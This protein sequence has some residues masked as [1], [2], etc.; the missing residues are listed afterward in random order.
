MVCRP[1]TNNQTIEFVRNKD[2]N[3]EKIIIHSMEELIEFKD[4]LLAEGTIKTSSPAALLKRDDGTL[5][6]RRRLGR[7]GDSTSKRQ[8]Q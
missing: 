4:K 3:A 1:M 5:G 7:D 2:S 8:H 6:K